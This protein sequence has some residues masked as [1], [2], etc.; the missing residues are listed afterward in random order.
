MANQQKNTGGGSL[1]E[2]WIDMGDQT[3]A[4]QTVQ[5]HAYYTLATGVA[6]QGATG[7]VGPVAGGDY[8]WRAEASNWNGA[9]ATLQF[10]GLD[11]STWFPVRNAANSADIALTANGS[12]AIGVAQG[13][14]LRVN[15][16]AANPTA[17][18]SALGGL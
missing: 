13:S 1:P 8:I 11:G 6:A 7:P 4:R 12:V 15:I 10:L 2:Q 18:N 3:F 14:I 16:T 17:F 9:T 5:A